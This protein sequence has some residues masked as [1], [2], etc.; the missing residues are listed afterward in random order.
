MLDGRWM[1]RV[2]IG[3]EATTRE[4]V[5]ALWNMIRE[6]VRQTST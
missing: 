5:K 1:V 4:H 3:V 6:Q 2:S